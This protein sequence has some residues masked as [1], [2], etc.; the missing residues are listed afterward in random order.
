MEQYDLVIAGGGLVGGSL[1]CA[2]APTGLRT[3]VVEAVPPRS[4]QQPS[5]DERVIALSY[6]SRLILEGI[7]LW[8]SVRPGAEPI[9]SIHISD[10]GHCGFARLTCSEF[11]VPALG[12]VAPARTIGAAIQGMLG[13]VEIAC[14]ARVE[15][16]CVDAEGVDLD[17]A[18]GDARRSVRARLLVAADGGDSTVRRLLGIG[19]RERPYDREA[20]ITTVSADRPR[21]GIAYERF[22]D[23]GPLAMLPMT[24]GRYSVVW[25]VSEGA[26]AEL[27]GLSDAAFI[28]RLQERFGY[29]AGTLTRPGRRIAY[30]LKLAFVPKPIHQRV[31]L[32]GNAAHMLHPVAGQGFNLGLRD[33]ATLADVLANAASGG[34]DPGEPC[35]LST[36]SRLRRADQTLVA[37]ATDGLAW[38][39][40]NPWWP[41]RL[42]RNLGLVAFDLLPGVRRVAATGFMGR[43]GPHS[44]LG[45]GLSLEQGAPVKSLHRF[46]DSP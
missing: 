38:L 32:I 28:A 30:P 41:V 7:G 10:R 33:V 36:Y 39:F 21:P 8:P 9:R 20:V 24:E 16:V 25:T 29:R 12:Y 3:L 2:L 44:R 4:S 31:A 13:G 1:A 45:R 34:V 26:S 15:G 46:E 37:R 43:L 23:A 22:T 14:P 17:I 35:T 11:G 18:E 27:L 40:V 42:G 6:G 5:Y 19:A